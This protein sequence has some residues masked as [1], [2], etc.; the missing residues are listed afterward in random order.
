MEQINPNTL[1]H[2]SIEEAHSIEV[3]W[4]NGNISL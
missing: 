1:L 3:I 4:I 2:G